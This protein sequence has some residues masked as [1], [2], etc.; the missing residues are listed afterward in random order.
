MSKLTVAKPHIYIHFW[1]RPTFGFPLLV[2]LLLLIVSVGN[3]ATLR[4]PWETVPLPAY[5][6]VGDMCGKPYHLII[7]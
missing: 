4:C 5:N 3:P 6:C 7:V 2:L 1:N